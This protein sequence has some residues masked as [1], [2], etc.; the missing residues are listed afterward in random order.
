MMPWHTSSQGGKKL[1]NHSGSRAVSNWAKTGST[2]T[3]PERPYHPSHQISRSFV[4]RTDQHL[5]FVH[6]TTKPQIL[7]LAKKKKKLKDH[8][9]GG[10]TCAP[11]SPWRSAYAP[12]REQF[13]AN[14]PTLEAADEVYHWL[15]KKFPPV[16][17]LDYILLVNNIAG[18]GNT[19][20][21]DRFR[22]WILNI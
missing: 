21:D 16:F 9:M 1:K 3:L 10:H 7:K 18:A 19:G 14:S 5:Q 22:L 11:T 20:D 4:Q 6:I 2:N 12:P 8:S 17:R 15:G 13:K